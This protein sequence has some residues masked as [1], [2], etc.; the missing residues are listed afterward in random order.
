[1]REPTGVVVSIFACGTATYTAAVQNG[2]VVGSCNP[3][4]EA[5]V[6]FVYNVVENQTQL[7]S[8]PESNWTEVTGINEQN[9]IWGWY[10]NVQNQ[11]YGFT[12]QGGVYT[13][14]SQAGYSYLI[15]TG[16]NKSGLVAGDA[17]DSSG[18]HHAFVLANGNFALANLPNAS[19]SHAVGLNNAGQ[20]AGNYTTTGGVMASFLWS[21][22]TNNYALLNAPGHGDSI[23]LN[24]INLRGQV[25]GSY[26]VDG[27]QI[28]FI[29]SCKGSL[30]K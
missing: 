15:P 3:A 16:V 28:A 14:L 24:A 22:A 25:A 7:L 27:K 4:L 30:C 2:L 17:V 9:V 19:K 26:Q 12:Y 20:V 10:Y 21:T 29:A 6:G 11:T 23:S 13:F 18:V 1:V 5:S 8:P